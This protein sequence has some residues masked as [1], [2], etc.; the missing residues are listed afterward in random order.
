MNLNVTKIADQVANTHKITKNTKQYFEKLLRNIQLANNSKS[1]PTNYLELIHSMHRGRLKCNQDNCFHI[2]VSANLVDRA[3]SFLN[4]LVI[5]LEKQQFKIMSIKK[6]KFQSAVV[7]IMD[8]QEIS[9]LVYEGYKYESTALDP[10]SLNE[11]ERLLYSKKK[12]VPTG[13]LTIIVSIKNTKLSRSWTDGKIMIED[14][15]TAIIS[16]FI[17]L[18]SRLKQY[19]VDLEKSNEQRKNDLIKLN[20]QFSHKL[21]QKSIYD[22]AMLEAQK[23]KIQIILEDYLN[24][25]ET[26]YIKDFGSLS[27]NAY[28]WIST[29][30]KI[31]K[32]E[33]AIMKRIKILNT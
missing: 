24:H 23:F 12:P 4:M 10:L 25:L 19:R 13:K 14:Y 20:E 22:D 5:E 3:L 30:R 31:A 28:D 17:S 29:A 11:F 15:L 2:T 33:S 8:H 18:P 7:A 27:K 16:E 1:L 21:L 26:E 9:F 32:T 6:Q